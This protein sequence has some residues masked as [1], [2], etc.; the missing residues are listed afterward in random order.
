MFCGY[1][2]TFQGND[3]WCAGQIDHLVH[4]NGVP[5]CWLPQGLNQ[6]HGDGGDDDA[7]E[8]ADPNLNQQSR[9]LF[10]GQI[11]G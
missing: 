5:Q 6:S 11:Q 3:V 1:K 9:R 10:E 2:P 7:N 8:N 4:G